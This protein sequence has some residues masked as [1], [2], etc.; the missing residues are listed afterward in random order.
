MEEALFNEI[1]FQICQNNNKVIAGKMMSS[2]AIV[3]KDK[4]FA[5]FSR[6]KKMVFKLGKE[7]DIASLD[8][9][10]KVFNPFKKRGPLNGWY[11]VP[12]AAKEHWEPLTQQAFN[13][14]KTE[15]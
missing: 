9:E 2:E 6:K 7:F 5:F 15:I 14:I 12:F 4:V 11:E 10:I 13:L 1:R 8:I 3:Y